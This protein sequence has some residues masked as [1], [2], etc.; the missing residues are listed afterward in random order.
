MNLVPSDKKIKFWSDRTFLDTIP[1]VP[2]KS[3]QTALGHIFS[4]QCKAKQ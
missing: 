3:S 1:L 2:P 4:Q